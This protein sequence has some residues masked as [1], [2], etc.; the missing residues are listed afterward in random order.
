[1]TS[2]KYGRERL[3]VA[4]SE[5]RLACASA[6]G[7]EA[8]VLRLAPATGVRRPS[9]LSSVERQR[10]LF[11]FEHGQKVTQRDGYG[12]TKPARWAMDT[13]SSISGTVRAST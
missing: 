6:Q 7:S 5:A 9:R 11:L 3:Q 1:M 10:Y 12:P 13:M 2:G 8:R 4:L